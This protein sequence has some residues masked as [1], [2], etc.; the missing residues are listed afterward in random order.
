MKLMYTGQSRNGK[1]VPASEI[2]AQIGQ[3]PWFAITASSGIEFG[4]PSGSADRWELKPQ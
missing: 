1:I 4:W 2:K 3:R